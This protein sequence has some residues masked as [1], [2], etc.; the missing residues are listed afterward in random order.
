MTREQIKLRSAIS[1]LTVHA[2]RI[3]EGLRAGG[4]VSTRAGASV[5]FDRYRGY[6]PGD[7]L[8]HLDWRV[9]ARSERLVIKR[10]RLETTLDVLLLV[11]VSGSMSFGSGGSWGSKFELATAI[12]GALAWLSVESGDRV[13]ACRCAGVDTDICLPRAGGAGLAQVM[14]LLKSPAT[15]GTRLTFDEV[16]RVVVAVTQR[17]GLVILLSDLLDPPESFQKGIG[18]LR[19]A[20]HD[21]LVIQ[22]LDRAERLFDVPDEVRLEDLE[23]ASNRRLHARAVR[24]DYL[25]AL[26]RHQTSIL[27]TCR[28]LHVDHMLV[29]PHDSPIPALRA[30]LQQRS[31]SHESPRRTG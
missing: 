4:H 21:V 20:G 25:D 10:A 14:E 22:V 29:D 7:D 2:R 13:S 6:Q 26:N 27:R 18:Q 1:N 11:D 12:A 5:E 24:D 9:F 19:H 15:S 30:M 8:R 23:G 16:S 17:P 28:G 31:G 3:I